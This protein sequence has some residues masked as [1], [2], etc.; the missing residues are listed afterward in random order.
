MPSWLEETLIFL[1]NSWAAFLLPA[2]VFYVLTREYKA[3]RFVLLT[4]AFFLYGTLIHDFLL[5]W[6]KDM[7]WRYVIWASNDITWM[8]IMMTSPVMTMSAMMISLPGFNISAVT[9]FPEITIA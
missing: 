1:N 5:D 4:A 9:P 3:L 8:A 6:D 7:I 2:I